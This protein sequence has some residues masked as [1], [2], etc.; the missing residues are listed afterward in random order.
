MSFG[1]L[2]SARKGK[3]IHSFVKPES[4][5]GFSD[6]MKADT[7]PGPL[8]SQSPMQINAAAPK[9]SH[10]TMVTDE[11]AVVQHSPLSQA[12]EEQAPPRTQEHQSPTNPTPV[13]T[14]ESTNSVNLHGCHTDLPSFLEIRESSRHG[15]GLYAKTALSAGEIILSI[16]PHV[17]VLSTP[18]LEYYC[19][20]CAAPAATAGL[21]RC[22]KCKTVR[23]CNSDCQNR[24]WAWHRRECN[25]LQ[26]WAA[27]A[28]SS[29]VAIPGEPVRCLGRIMWGSQKEGLDSVWAQEIRM[30]HSNRNSL[31][32]SAF[33]S[34]THLAHSV[35]RYLGV[36]SPQEL[37]PYGLKSAGDLVDLI[38][39]FTTNTFTLTTPALTP[40]GICVS[41]TVALA[42]H[43]CDPNAALVFP[44]ADGGSRVKEPLLSLVALRNVAPGKEIRISYVDTTL[45]NRLRQNELKEVYSFSCQCKLCCRT[46]AA[47]P[48][49]ALWCPKSCGGICPYPTEESGDRATHCVKC[50]AQVG[51][52]GAVLDALRVGQ[53]ALD[54]ASSLQSKDRVKARQLTTNITPILTSA[55]VTPSSHP[56]LALTRLHKE[57]LIDSLSSSSPTQETLD[58]AVRT[59]ARYTAGLQALLPKGH[60]VR[61]VALGELGKLLA[62]DEPAPTSASDYAGAEKFPPSGPPRLKLAYESFV[63][64]HEELLIGF[65]K[66]SGGGLLGAEIREAIMRLEKEL[67]IWTTGIR[68]V[69]EDTLVSAQRVGPP[70]Q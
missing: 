29:D 2:K 14:R 55:G 33:G 17:F 70:S 35:V 39:R 13:K 15:R 38:S 25:A 30:M 42:N 66:K 32:P 28:P 47:D 24:D 53:E 21:K 18:N 57:L 27:S 61:A 8:P 49:E 62:V 56:L 48:R 67:G 52:V 12:S 3:E 54:K 43:S 40:I 45:P 4:V 41:P 34:H 50:N 64:A 6:T 46:T 63:K 19:S 60:P 5:S 59:A 69:L 26:K 1:K 16:I 37:E 7:S 10:D 44:R 9:N 58:E 22:P 11:Q 36:S 31:Q 51:D 68:N 65:G 23:Y 20:A